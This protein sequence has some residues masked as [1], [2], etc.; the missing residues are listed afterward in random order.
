MPTCLEL[1]VELLLIL[2]GLSV[3][4]ER[5]FLSGI[6]FGHNVQRAT[7]VP[8]GVSFLLGMELSKL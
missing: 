6:L 4:I 7:P 5:E 2:V 8:T 1:L 3:H